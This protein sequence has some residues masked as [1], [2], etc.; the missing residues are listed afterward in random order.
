MSDQ[1][2]R[3]ILIQMY[4]RLALIRKVELRIEEEYHCD[5]MKT[6]VHLSL[7]QEAA[8]VGVCV[9]LRK[10]DY[11]FSNHRSHAHYLAKGGNLK[12]MI[13]EFYCRETGCAHGRGG[14]MHLID[15]S[16]NHLG[17]SSMVGG[18]VPHAMGAAFA[19]RFRRE[20]RVAV[21]FMG[22]AATEQGV[23][24]ETM[25]WAKMH[26]LPVV[27]VCENNLYSVY[28]HIS[29]RQPAS[30][31]ARRPLAFDIPAVKIDG[32][33]VLE[34]YRH[35]QNALEHARSGKGPYFIECC[36]QRWRGHAGEGDP[37]KEKYRR[38]EELA[39][40]YLRD[41]LKDFSEYLLGSQ[42]VLSAE[43]AQIDRQLDQQIDE[44]FRF[45]KE[46][47]LPSKEDLGKYLYS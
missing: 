35:A 5:E 2:P 6:P 44:A 1:I 13:A 45:A 14:S 20:D 31:I 38:Q 37:L 3:D 15:T 27:F 10:T 18:S 12:A 42:N 17:S 16:V 25:A 7:G 30:D 46:S 29:A 11:I 33:N 28:S 47:P 23:F 9:H 34:V 43:L 32:M 8:A 19:A 41:P 22:D 39:E 36:V 24:Y 4:A 21:S 26:D 40:G